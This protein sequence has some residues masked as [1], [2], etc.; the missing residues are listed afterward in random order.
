MALQTY[1]VRKLSVLEDGR[2]LNNVTL[3]LGDGSASYPAGGIPL[4]KA[5]LGLVAYIDSVAVQ[6]DAGSTRMYKYDYAN[7]KLRIYV[8]GAAVYAEMSG[9]VPSISLD[10]LVIGN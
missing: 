1:T 5:D 3:A 2:K 10:L 9:T 4:S 7:E 6:N 8:E